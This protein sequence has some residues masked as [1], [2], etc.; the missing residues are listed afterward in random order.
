MMTMGLRK[1]KNT[2]SKIIIK[3]TQIFILTKLHTGQFNHNTSTPTST[4][5]HHTTPHHTT[6]HHTTPHHTTPH[7]TTPHHT[8]PHHTTPHHTTPH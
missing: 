3:A 1:L 6:P 4:P 2:D 7:H 8:T 5:S